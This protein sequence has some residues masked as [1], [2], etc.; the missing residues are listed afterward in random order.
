MVSPPTCTE[1]KRSAECSIQFKASLVS[2]LLFRCLKLSSTS[3]IFHQE[4][5]RLRG[6]LSRNSYPLEFIDQCISAFLNKT[7]TKK[8]KAPA[9]ETPSETI[10]HPYLGKLSLEIR[11]RLRKYV[12]KHIKS[13]KLNIIFRSQRRLKT[14]FRF[15]DSIPL[16]LQ[17][18]ILY[19]FTCRTC[20]CSYIGKTDRHSHIRCYEHLKLIPTRRRPFK[21]KQES[22]AIHLHIKSAEHPSSLEDFIIIG[23]ENTRND[24]K[25]KIK[26]S[27]LIRKH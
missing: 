24:F 27:L 2:T 4:V 18:Y 21:S 1:R 20:N 7:F 22:A 15:K 16:A 12:S 23:R 11:N 26:E 3:D 25:L 9:D 5:E 14:L 10:V 6:I 17:S 19:R 13:C 8:E